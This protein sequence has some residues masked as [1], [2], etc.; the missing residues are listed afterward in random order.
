MPGERQGPQLQEQQVQ[1]LPPELPVQHALQ[2][3]VAGTIMQHPH[4][5]QYIPDLLEQP[6]AVQ[7]SREQLPGT[8]AEQAHIQGLLQR[9]ITHTAGR[10]IQQTGLLLLIREATVQNRHR[11]VITG[12][13]TLQIHQQDQIR[14]QGRLPETVLPGQ[15]HIPLQAEVQ[16]VAVVRAEVILLRAEAVVAVAVVAEVIHQ[17]AAGHPVH[18]V[19]DQALVEAEVQDQ[20]QAEEDK[21]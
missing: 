10:Q 13:L 2:L 12:P 14:I 17:V 16:A 3:R 20:A 5:G 6:G 18:Q 4:K 1:Q 8:V 7:P 11:E 15:E 19:R 21:K 9:I